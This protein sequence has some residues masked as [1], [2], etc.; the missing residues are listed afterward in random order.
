MYWQRTTGTVPR[1]EDTTAVGDPAGER[2]ILHL[3]MDAFYA[4]VEERED[5]G[6]VGK[7]VIVGGP[8]EGRGV[9][10]AANYEARRFGVH[11]A[12]P[13]AL[14]ARLCPHGVFIA[15]R[16]GLYS[17]VSR[18]VH[19]VL[20]RYTPLIEPLALDE[21]FLDITG[22]QALFGD[23]V[24]IAARIKRE[25]LDATRLVASVGLAPNKFLAKLASD[26]RKPDALVIVRRG[27][28][29]A[30]LDPLPVTRVWGVGRRTASILERIGVTT[31]ADLRR[32]SDELLNEVFGHSGARLRE[33]AEGQDDRPVVPDHEA[34]S[35]SH[36]TTFSDDVDSR[37]TLRLWLLDL[38]DQVSARCRRLELEGRTVNIKVRFDDFRTITRSITLPRPTSVSSEVRAAVEELFGPRL[39]VPLRPVR[40]VGV[41]L[42][43]FDGAAAPQADLFGDPDR[44][45]AISLDAVL[46]RAR[47]RFGT[48]AL[49]RGRDPKGDPKGER[50]G[51]H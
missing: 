44:E 38:A 50:G 26:V 18:D 28:E 4:S 25:V 41:G 49:R 16:H 7:P 23:A 3:D 8:A 6:L 39:G 14:A 2:W 34:R 45:R 5:P 13:S 40:L 47:N 11:S 27:E 36:E 10:S 33:L 17:E 51:E 32:Q 24:D 21:A 1:A 20:E 9:V 15:P 31:I 46:D 43:G 30:F 37:D 29:R 22:S 19:Q 12:Q 42:A 35:V 48:A